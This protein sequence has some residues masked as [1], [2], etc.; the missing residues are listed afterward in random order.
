MVV[1]L[2]GGHV[3]H[4]DRVGAL[5]PEQAGA[6][7]RDVVHPVCGGGEHLPVAGRGAVEGVV[8]GRAGHQRA[9]GVVDAVQ[10]RPV[11]S[12]LAEVQRHQV[13]VV[14]LGRLQG[15]REPVVVA[16]ELDRSP[17]AVPPTVDCGCGG[18]VGWVVVGRAAGD[19]GD[20]HRV[21]PLAVAAHRQVVG[22]GC[23]GGVVDAGVPIRAAVVDVGSG[24]AGA[25]GA[26]QRVDVG[27]LEG[28]VEGLEQLLA[29]GVEPVGLVGRQG[30][31]EP[32][33]VALSL[34]LTGR[35]A[36]RRPPCRSCRRCW[37]RSR[38]AAG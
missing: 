9:G 11:E 4:P 31:R 18:G 15:D 34:D 26:V 29:L 17:V 6:A 1:G 32:V 20:R 38:R 37:R 22:P 27:V 21:G 7:G 28:A 19:V 5:T 36:R 35:G 10:G 30:D 13:D 3:G 2:A 25:V 14:G 23:G 8:V 12:P 33:E 16:V 24:D